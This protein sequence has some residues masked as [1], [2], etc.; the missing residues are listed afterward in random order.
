MSRV[1]TSTM[2]Y[3]TDTGMMFDPSRVSARSVQEHASGSQLARDDD[4][5]DM[6]VDLS[7]GSFIPV[8]LRSWTVLMEVTDKLGKL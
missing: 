5:E 6:M 8:N 4:S 7:T 1:T 3:N 2:I